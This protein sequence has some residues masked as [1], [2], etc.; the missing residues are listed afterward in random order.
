MVHGINGARDTSLKLVSVGLNFGS[1]KKGN[2][3]SPP[4]IDFKLSLPRLSEVAADYANKGYELTDG[5]LLE[6]NDIVGTW[7]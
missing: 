3:F 7:I 2:F 1:I 6:C 4:S 5:S